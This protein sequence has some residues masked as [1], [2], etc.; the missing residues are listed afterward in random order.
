MTFEQRR[1]RILCH[2]PFLGRYLLSFKVRAP[3][4]EENIKTA[5]IESDGTIVLCDEFADTLSDDELVGVFFHEHRGLLAQ[6]KLE[7]RRRWLNANFFFFKALNLKFNPN[8]TPMVL[9]S[10]PAC[11]E[12]CEHDE[13]RCSQ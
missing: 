8:P 9:V 6:T 2:K 3:L 11:D 10:E 4:P 1:T 12:H 13:G 7:A 5:A